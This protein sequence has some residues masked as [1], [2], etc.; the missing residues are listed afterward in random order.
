MNLFTFAKH[1]KLL[2]LTDQGN[3]TFSVGIKKSGP[4]ILWLTYESPKEL[5]VHTR[6][7]QSKAQDYFCCKLSSQAIT[8]AASRAGSTTRGKP[9]SLKLLL[10]H[11]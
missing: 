11:S 4:A 1:L 7:S 9:H 8:G 3:K 10:R 2:F 5:F 6:F